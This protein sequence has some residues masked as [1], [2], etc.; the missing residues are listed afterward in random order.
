MN[1]YYNLI[2]RLQE[3]AEW[4]EANIWE[5]PIMLPD[6]IYAAI[7]AI[8]TLSKQCENLE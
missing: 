7:E 8:K 1:K 4:A 2:E 6:D 3:D 5:V